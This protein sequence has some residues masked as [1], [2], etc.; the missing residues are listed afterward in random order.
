MTTYD[1]EFQILGQFRGQGPSWKFATRYDQ[2][3]AV[4]CFEKL[5][6]EQANFSLE[7]VRIERTITRTTLRKEEYGIIALP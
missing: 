6:A 1:T 7:L 5:A 4:Q 2:I 3:D